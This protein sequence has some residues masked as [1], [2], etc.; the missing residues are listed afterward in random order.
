MAA[1]DRILGGIHPPG[2]YRFADSMGAADV[3]RRVERRGWVGWRLSG[4][5]IENKTAFLAVCNE[6][7]G[8]PAYFGRNWDAFEECITDLRWAPATGYVLLYDEPA[9]FA[10][11]QPDQWRMALDILRAAVEYW[12]R[13]DTPFFALLRRTHGVAPDV[14]FLSAK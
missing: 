11:A 9:R 8:F 10:I 13:R 7:M 5:L 6:S 4:R 1:L 14:P 3:L 2:V 12:Q